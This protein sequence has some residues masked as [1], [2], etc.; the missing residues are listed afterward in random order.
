MSIELVQQINRFRSFPMYDR[1]IPLPRRAR[2][3][4]DRV[5]HQGMP[6]QFQN[7]VIAGA[8]AIGIGAGQIEAH[9]LSMD[10]DQLTLARAI[11]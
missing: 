3:A 4:P 9:F 1:P 11:G 5:D 7:V 6:D 10:K 2:H 8:I